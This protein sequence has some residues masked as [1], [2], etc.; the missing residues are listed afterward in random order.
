MYYSGIIESTIVAE[1]EKTQLNIS[2][3]F[4]KDKDVYV[5]SDYW[6]ILVKFDVTVYEE[7]ITILPTLVSELE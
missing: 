4:M 6:R 3:S 5:T 1:V 2:V 7:A